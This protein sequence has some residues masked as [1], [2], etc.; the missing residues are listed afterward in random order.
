MI[1]AGLN[2]LFRIIRKIIETFE[3]FW[4]VA[5]TI[6]NTSTLMNQRSSGRFNLL[7]PNAPF[8]PPE[9]IIKLYSFLMFSRVEKVYIENEW[10]TLHT[11]V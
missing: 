7:V 5:T 11:A 9:N 6:N 8:L 4:G 10:V 2:F 1:S 3:L